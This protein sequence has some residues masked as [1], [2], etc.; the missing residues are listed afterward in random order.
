MFYFYRMDLVINS[1]SFVGA[2]TFV[3]F[4][5]A[6]A[7]RACFACR[8]AFH[9]GAWKS[10]C[11]VYE[12]TGDFANAVTRFAYLLVVGGNV[13]AAIAVISQGGANASAWLLSAFWLSALGTALV[14]IGA[15][16]GAVD[17][18]D[19]G[20]STVWVLRHVLANIAIAA[21]PVVS[22]VAVK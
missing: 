9:E 18:E 3:I 12:P 4:W 2:V 22:F 13:L 7:D 8:L 21:A 5:A 10:N 6:V 17:G 11:G 1:N 16:H 15:A 14:E 19:H 20:D